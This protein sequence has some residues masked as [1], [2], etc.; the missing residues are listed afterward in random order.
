MSRFWDD[1]GKALAAVAPLLGSAIGGPLG[2]TA[3]KLVISALGLDPATPEPEVAAAV[4]GATP[5]Q[6]LALKKADQDFAASMKA[7]DLSAERIAAEDRA[8]AR[9]RE[10]A[11]HDWVP[12]VLMLLLTLGFFGLLG[13]LAVAEV[14]VGNKD[15]LNI[16]LGALGTA[17]T[18]GVTYYFGSS[19]GA[20]AKDRVI[21]SLVG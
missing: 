3:V 21:K 17:W 7:L 6:L 13:Y 9:G 14:P 20:D 1:A 16:M 8:S 11:L 4:A 12:G 19:A 18:G 10:A 15:M 5:D 2:G